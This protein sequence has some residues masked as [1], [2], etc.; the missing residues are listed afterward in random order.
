MLYN[1]TQQSC[2]MLYNRISRIFPKT[3]PKQ[4]HRDWQSIMGKRPYRQCFCIFQVFLLTLYEIYDIIGLLHLF[5]YAFPRKWTQLTVNNLRQGRRRRRRTPGT[6]RAATCPRIVSGDK[7][8]SPVQILALSEMIYFSIT[9]RGASNRSN[10]EAAA[11]DLEEIPRFPERLS[12]SCLPKAQS[13]RLSPDRLSTKARPLYEHMTTLNQKR[14]RRIS[15]KSLR[16]RRRPGCDCRLAFGA[17][18]GDG[19]RE[20]A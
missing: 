14:R 18:T 8:G 10:R 19:E 9:R 7:N 13:R 11:E 20:A 17:E 3:K 16:L 15:C 12:P 5:F 6:R 2:T 1:L 4:N